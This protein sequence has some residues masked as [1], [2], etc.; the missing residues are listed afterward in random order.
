M[1][2]SRAIPQ[3]FAAL[4][5]PEASEDRARL[6]TRKPLGEGQR[7]SFR[8]HGAEPVSFSDARGA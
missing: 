2:R 8:F 6:E 3:P 5:L 4:P 7:F 1:M